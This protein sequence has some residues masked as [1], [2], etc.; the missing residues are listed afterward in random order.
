MA[1]CVSVVRTESGLNEALGV[2]RR[3]REQYGTVTIDDRGSVFNQDVIGA[4]ELG[5]M[6]DCAEV[7]VVSAINRTESRGGHFREDFPERNDEEWLKHTVVHKGPDG[8]TLGYS[9]VTITK[10]QPEER[11]Y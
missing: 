10:W 2:I 6:L 7:M 5:N 1:R 3:I 11:T 4:L 9:D 8:P